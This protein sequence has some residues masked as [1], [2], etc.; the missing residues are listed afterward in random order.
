MKRLGREMMLLFSGLTGKPSRRIFAVAAAL[1]LAGLLLGGCGLKADPVPPV[2]KRE[3]VKEQNAGQTSK[4]DSDA[5]EKMMIP[6]SSKHEFRISKQYPMTKIQMTETPS[7]FYSGIF[8]SRFRSFGHSVNRISN[9]PFGVAQGGEPVEPSRISDFEIRI[10]GYNPVFNIS[11]R[12][13]AAL[14][15]PLQDE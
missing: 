3:P 5:G 6:V 12:H 2:R 4:A 9:L 1:L 13:A 10:C 7:D 14:H 8:K 15:F 11:L